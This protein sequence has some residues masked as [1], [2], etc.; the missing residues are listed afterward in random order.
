[1]TKG[2]IKY[3][4][5][6]DSYTYAEENRNSF[7]AATNKMDY[8][9]QAIVASGNK[10]EIISPS[11]T[12]NN[13]GYYHKRTSTIGEGVTLTCGPTF[14]AYRPLFRYLRILWSWIWLF[15]YLV[16]NTNSEETIIAYHSMMIINPIMLAK[17]IK[18]FKLILEVEEI[19]QDVKKYSQLMQSNEYRFFKS[20]D[21]FIF[22]T[23]LL[24]EKINKNNKPYNIIYGTYKVEQ[25]RKSKF[26]DGK[27]H[28]VYAGTFDPI[29][30]GS[31]IAATVAPYLPENYH[32][33]IIGFGSE[34]ETRSIQ[35]LISE[36]AKTSVCTIT[37]DGLLKDEEYTRFLQSCDIG[38]ST[39]IPGGSYNNTSFPSKILSYMANGLR[40][41][42]VR[43]KAIEM[44]VIGDA[45]YYYKE[46]TPEAIAEAIMSIDINE[47]YDSKQLIKKL[48]E[49]FVHTI[50]E[51]LEN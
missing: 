32:I 38:L 40:V 46:Q 33:H 17:K 2:N 4:G 39:Q 18:K 8:I 51:L 24:I 21:K 19:Y 45:V 48:D 36:I 3:I 41:V 11:W 15:G 50:K 23:E 26:N 28:C 13:K 9:C 30:G 37:Y 10:V 12:A 6:Y 44:S 31:T 22:P 29:K 25:D 5:F 16:K 43:I 42:S 49:K 34:E 47:P 14:G 1:M 20:A 35:Q 7:L 27:V